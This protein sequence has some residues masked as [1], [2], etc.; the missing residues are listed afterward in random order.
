MQAPKRAAS[1]LPQSALRHA[2]PWGSS[3][4]LPAC[5]RI[6]CVLHETDVDSLSSLL[7]ASTVP[8]WQDLP[9]LL[10]SL[11]WPGANPDGEGSDRPPG[12][13]T[14]AYLVMQLLEAASVIK[15]ATGVATLGCILLAVAVD[16]IARRGRLPRCCSA[17]A[18]P[19][20]WCVGRV[21]PVS[22]ALPVCRGKCGG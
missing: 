13:L 20:L 11:A 6:Q 4:H 12:L 16:A 7:G 2:D 9:P 3:S 17:C 5:C 19:V 22:S 8:R 21:L 1:L 10:R 14:K 15:E 18:C